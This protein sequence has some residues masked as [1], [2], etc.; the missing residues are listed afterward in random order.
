MFCVVDVPL[1]IQ[2]PVTDFD[3]MIKVEW[4]HAEIIPIFM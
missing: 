4:R 3:R 1:W 2:I